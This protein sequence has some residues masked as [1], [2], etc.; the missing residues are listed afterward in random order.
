[1]Q[2]LFFARGDGLVS[3]AE[4][5]AMRG[6][7]YASGHDV[8][9]EGSKEQKV[10]GVNDVVHG[11]EA[12]LLKLAPPRPINCALVS[13]N[14][15]IRRELRLHPLYCDCVRRL[16][17]LGSLDM[18][19]CHPSRRTLRAPVPVEHCIVSTAPPPCLHLYDF[20]T[21]GLHFG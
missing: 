1:M 10:C 6:P 14:P 4:V 12:A 18:E 19:G 7:V 9:V 21:W 11:D 15:L 2:N 8:V 5:V 13:C 16:D 17:G 20:S 3:A